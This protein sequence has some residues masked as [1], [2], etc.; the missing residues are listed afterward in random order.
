MSLGDKMANRYANKGVV[1]K[2]LPNELRPYTLKNKTPIDCI[3]GPI[4]VISRMN[5][6]QVPEGVVAKVITHVE[7]CIKADFGQTSPMLR[8]LSDISNIL[9]DNLYSQRIGNLCNEI[10]HDPVR[11]EEFIASVRDLGLYFEAPNFAN[12]DQ[13][14]LT[15]YI[16]EKFDIQPNEAIVYTRE[17]LDYMKNE[18]KL[19]D[20]SIPK[21]DLVIKSIF[22]VPIYMLK[23]KQEA[24]GRVSCR[25]FGN[26]KSTNKQPIQ[27]RNKDGSIGQGS[28]LGQMEFDGLLAHNVPS[29]VKELRTVKNDSQ[30]AKIDITTQIISTNTYHLPEITN[31][32]FSPTKEIIE[33]CMK[34]LN[35]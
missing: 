11:R 18:L 2:I 22:T 21:E 20:L 32:S 16:D 31:D 30:A 15:N 8:K 29:A 35:S 26:Y 10:D 34:F 3:V 23:L 28:K 17:M 33:A 27:G 9:G 14:E 5:Y 7:K 13:N 1:S 19:Y 12:Y 24:A 25:D 6:G 4:S